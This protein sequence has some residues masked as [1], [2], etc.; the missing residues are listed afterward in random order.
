MA[1]IDIRELNISARLSPEKLI[2]EAEENYRRNITAAADRVAEDG[3]VKLVLL[4]G[5]SGSGKTTS[6]NILADLLSEKGRHAEVI[7]LDHFYKRSDDPS[8]PKT[9]SG[10]NDCESIDALDLDAIAKCLGE[11]SHGKKQVIYKYDFSLGRPSNDTIE[12]D[13]GK[14]GIIIV[15]GL[16]ALN[17]KV[18]DSLPKEALFNIFVSVSTNINDGGKR[19][20]SGRKLRFLRRLVRDS[21]YRGASAERTLGMWRDVLAGEDKYLYPFRDRADVAFN[22][23]H[24]FELGVLKPLGEKLLFGGVLDDEYAAA[25]KHALDLTEEVP[26]ALVPDTSLIRE[27]IPG[28]IYESLY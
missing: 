5:P 21:I 23:F 9:E 10:A 28:G 7:S 14:N 15:E 26:E 20:L 16:H 8:Y 24:S 4:A 6:A 11:L 12:L 13:P 22:T 2:A 3:K 1:E 19:V 27:F 25:V 17:P 18:S